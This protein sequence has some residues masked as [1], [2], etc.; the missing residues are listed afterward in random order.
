MNTNICALTICFVW[1]KK[2]YAF[3]FLE[4]FSWHDL[5]HGCFRFGK[6]KLNM[7]KLV[8][9]MSQQYRYIFAYYN[10]CKSVK[11]KINYLLSCVLSKHLNIYHFPHDYWRVNAAFQ[12]IKIHNILLTLMSILQFPKITA[13][14]FTRYDVRDGIKSTRVNDHDHPA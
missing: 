10:C 9:C 7:F 12:G 2:L 8:N 3:N 4:M 6:L 5:W 1:N 13:A 11:C 14:I